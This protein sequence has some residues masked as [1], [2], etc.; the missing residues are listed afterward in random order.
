MHA[1][2]PRRG[3]SAAMFP[4]SALRRGRSIARETM[5]KNSG[6]PDRIDV[7]DKSTDTRSVE[8]KLATFVLPRLD[9]AASRS[10]SLL[11]REWALQFAKMRRLKPQRKDK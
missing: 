1:E 5:A 4:Q 6:S 3:Q 10:V 2:T 8:R 11:P 9:R 7:R